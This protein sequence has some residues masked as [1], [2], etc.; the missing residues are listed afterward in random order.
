MRKHTGMRPQD[1]VVLLKMI[2]LGG[3]SWR[4]TDLANQ[5]FMSQSEVSEA[6][7]R[8][9]IAGLTDESKKKVFRDS[10]LEFLVHGLRYVFPEQPGALV[11]GI[12]TAHSAEPLSKKILSAEAD[13]YVWPFSEGK[14]RGQ[15]INPLFK[16][17]PKAALEDPKLYELLALTEALRVGKAREFKLASE[18]L[19]KRFK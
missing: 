7:N 8:C 10:L 19:S 2:S 17:A 4:I 18:E 12:P 1:I 11:K 3:K 9:K 14:V 5:L 6:L 16:T 13:C 15:A